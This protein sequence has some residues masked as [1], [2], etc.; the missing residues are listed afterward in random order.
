MDARWSGRRAPGGLVTSRGLN[1]GCQVD[2]YEIPSVEQ[3]DGLDTWVL[4]EVIRG[5][6]GDLDVYLGIDAGLKGSKKNSVPRL[7]RTSGVFPHASTF[8]MWIMLAAWLMWLHFIYSLSA[9][10]LTSITLSSLHW[11]WPPSFNWTHQRPSYCR[12]F[13]VNVPSTWSSS[14]RSLRI[15]HYLKYQPQ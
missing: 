1:N 9:L 6:P 13:V 14:P 2:I 15:K 11:H 8:I 4:Q 3:S 10:F 5:L 12:T 7:V